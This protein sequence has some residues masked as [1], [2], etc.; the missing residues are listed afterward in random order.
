MV[1]RSFIDQSKKTAIQVI[2]TK[3]WGM[4]DEF[5]HE[6]QIG[7]NISEGILRVDMG[8]EIRSYAPGC[9][10]RVISR[11]VFPRAQV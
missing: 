10:T 8:D 2:V 3:R 11:R 9:W 6:Q 5:Y 7:V 1:G 4:T